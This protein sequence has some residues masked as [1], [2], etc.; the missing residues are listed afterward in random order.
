LLTLGES[1]AEVLEERV[2][3]DDHAGDEE[4]VVAC[5]G[6]DVVHVA[7]FASRFRAHFAVE[8]LR[9]AHFRLRGST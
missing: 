5:F 6:A 9:E 1:D 8:E 2:T 4:P 3:A 7:E